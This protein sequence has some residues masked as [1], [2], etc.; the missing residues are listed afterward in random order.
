MINKIYKSI[1]SKYWNFFKFFFFLRYV[2]IIFLI[3]ISLF[4]IIPKFFDYEKKQE[5]IKKYLIS[6]YGLELKKHELINFYV[7]PTPNLQIEN[8]SLE[9]IDKSLNLKSKK[10]NIFLDYKNI[11]NY[12]NF[13]SRRILLTEI[14]MSF[15]V[16]KFREFINYLNKLNLKAVFKNLN[17]NFKKDD[18]FLIKIEDINFSNYGYKK[19]D[20]NGMIFDKKFKA[21]L[22]KNNQNLNFKIL[23]TGVKANFDFEEKNLKNTI[24]GSSKISF[25][26]NLL[27]FNFIL[28]NEQLKINK[29]NFKNKNLSIS[30]DSQL[31]LDPFFIS[32]SNIYI[33]EID[34]D[35]FSKINLDKIL[36][37][38][39]IIK[40]LNS[41]INVYYKKKKY[42]SGLIDSYSSDVN[43][44]YGRLFF[45]NK[46]LTK[47]GEL[48]CEGD[49]LFSDEYPRLNLIC[50]LIIKDKKKFFKYF[51]IS[52][53]I[54][55][56]LIVGEIHSSINLIN[57]RIN[58][59]RIKFGKN[60]LANEEEMRF[61]KEKFED[62]LF[63]KSF[64]NI[65]ETDKIKEFIAQTN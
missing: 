17:L 2:F 4:L 57:Q 23:D 30:L 45:S 53:D 5:I 51:S 54:G 15:E 24:Q 64:F 25:L 18:A 38:K 32:N 55:D 59:K 19:Y 35:F 13:K 7:F 60:Y 65:F 12:E 58:F 34:K 8:V 36:V 56:D 6:S 3:S 41:N 22:K 49:V 11:Y 42:Q 29:S 52:K 10:L 39:E 43:L 46:I 28:E 50:A 47:G 26:D 33:K 27:K 62:I 31:R 21:S 44:A 63:D 20:I 48:N 9:I 40:K 14:D 16:N 37:N 1:H 61:F